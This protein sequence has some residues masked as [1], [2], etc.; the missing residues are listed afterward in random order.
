M[1]HAIV[2]ALAAVAATAVAAATSAPSFDSD[3]RG[4]PAD[5]P[6]QT[7]DVALTSTGSHPKVG[8]PTFAAGSGSGLPEIAATLADV[9]AYDLD[10]EREFYIIPRK[11]SESIPVAATPEAL[12]FDRWSA[13]GA[14]YVLLGTVQE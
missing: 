9:L 14:D 6:Q 1:R 10:F 8:V 4:W 5:A 2:L 3:V 12:P 11:A 13:I 7:I